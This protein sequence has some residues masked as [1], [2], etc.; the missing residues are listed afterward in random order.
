MATP[1][2][3]W[4]EVKAFFEAAQELSPEEIPGFL[5][6]TCSDPAVRAE[7]ERL[8]EEYKQAGRFLSSG[9]GAVAYVSSSS[10]GCLPGDVVGAFRITDFLA[11]GGMGV[12]YKAVDT[13]LHRNVALKFLPEGSA[14]DSSAEVRL[15][16]EAQAAS[17]LN[18]PNICTIYEIGKHEGR[19]FIAMEYLDG[20]TL[21]SLIAGQPLEIEM[22]VK[23]GIEIAE[24]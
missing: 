17:A 12:V 7:V 8:L 18:H 23:L 10:Q 6:K 3:K 5:E 14:Y 2:E 19:T 15:Q 9:G 11:R 1:R 20:S 24:A 4:D 21:K 22:L 16:R 13:R